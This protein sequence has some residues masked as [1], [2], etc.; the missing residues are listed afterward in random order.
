MIN[1]IFMDR[2]ESGSTDSNYS[3][4]RD[5][6]VRIHR[7]L[8]EKRAFDKVIWYLSE[9]NKMGL[10]TGKIERIGARWEGCERMMETGHVAPSECVNSV[11]GRYGFRWGVNPSLTR[12]LEMCN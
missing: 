10:L 4:E 5:D 6:E 1:M 12:P 8:R 7:S 11:R 2:G 3:S 9:V